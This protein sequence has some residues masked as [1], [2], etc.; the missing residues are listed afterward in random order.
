MDAVAD[1]YKDE[2]YF[3]MYMSSIVDSERWNDIWMYDCPDGQCEE[4]KPNPPE[5]G[6]MPNPPEEGEMPNPPE[7]GETPSPPDDGECRI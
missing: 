2:I 7:E 4:N 6:E 3:H 5:E 1:Q